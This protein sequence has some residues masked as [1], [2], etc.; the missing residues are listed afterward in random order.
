[1]IT[2]SGWG[3]FCAEKRNPSFPFLKSQSLAV[4]NQVEPVNPSLLI[5]PSILLYAF[6]PIVLSLGTHSVTRGSTYYLLVVPHDQPIDALIG[7][8]AVCPSC[9]P[10][11]PSLSVSIFK[12]NVNHNSFHLSLV[13]C[14]L[15]QQSIAMRLCFTAVCY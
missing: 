15:L 11:C 2:L 4:R 12:S 6:L 8:V 5:H 1:M 3:G 13:S 9:F 7:Y 10:S 14:K